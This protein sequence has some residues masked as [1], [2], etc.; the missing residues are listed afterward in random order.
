VLQSLEAAILDFSL[1]IKSYNI[2]NSLIR[3]VDYENIDLVSE[4]IFLSML[5]TIKDI[6]HVNK[7]LTKR[8]QN[9]K[10]YR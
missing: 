3:Q 9:I 1:P 10:T 4:I 7:M 5:L 8:K 6:P 2:S